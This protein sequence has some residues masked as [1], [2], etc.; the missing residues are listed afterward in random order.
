MINCIII[1]DEPKAID[2]I[3]AFVG[4]VAF[5]NL[6]SKFRDPVEALGY[7]VENKPD[8]IFWT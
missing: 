5:L 4:K 8:L 3:A 1:D 6:T 7:I 2:V